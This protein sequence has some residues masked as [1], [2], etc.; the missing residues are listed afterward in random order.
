VVIVI[1][2]NF[3]FIERQQEEQA[4]KYLRHSKYELLLTLNFRLEAS[5]KRVFLGNDFKTTQANQ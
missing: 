2:T 1:D 4:K 5:Y 3:N